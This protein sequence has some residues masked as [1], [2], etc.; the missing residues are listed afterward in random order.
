MLTM[1][2]L[3]RIPA[4]GLARA[5]SGVTARE[6]CSMA[7][8]RPG[9]GRSSTDMVASGVTS[10]GA[11][12]GTA[13]TRHTHHHCGHPPVP[14]VVRMMSAVPESAQLTRAR[15]I[16]AAVSGTTL[17]ATTSS[18]GSAPASS[19]SSGPDRSWVTG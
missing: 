15:R 1:T 8:T 10:R 6:P 9:A 13:V 5:A 2:V 16:S 4:A 17:L 3:P 19:H 12:P 7:A 11:N 18:P 14:P